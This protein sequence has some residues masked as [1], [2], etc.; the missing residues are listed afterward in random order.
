MKK[1]TRSELWVVRVKP[2]TKC[3]LQAA[4]KKLD[5]LS[6]YYGVDKDDLLLSLMETAIRVF[7]QQRK[8]HSIYEVISSVENAIR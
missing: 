1:A 4:F 6:R 5:I 7:E 2:T 8:Q 3:R